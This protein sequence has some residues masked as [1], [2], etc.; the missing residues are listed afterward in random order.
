MV[1]RSSVAC[2]GVRRSLFVCLLVGCYGTGIGAD[3]VVDVVRAGDRCGYGRG[4]SGV[5]YRRR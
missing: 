5:G 4:R 2:G 3:M 1:A